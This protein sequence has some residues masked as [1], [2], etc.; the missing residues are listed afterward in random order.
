MVLIS[1]G[2][3]PDYDKVIAKTCGKALRWISNLTKTTGQYSCKML[4]E[5][6]CSHAAKA[7]PNLN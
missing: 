4:S 6:G 7:A 5:D 3:N 1:L 2:E